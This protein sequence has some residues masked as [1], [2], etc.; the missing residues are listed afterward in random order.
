MNSSRSL[1]PSQN[2]LKNAKVLFDIYKTTNFQPLVKF[3]NYLCHT[4][5]LLQTLDLDRLHDK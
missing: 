3:K 5:F 1:H 2:G 4:Q